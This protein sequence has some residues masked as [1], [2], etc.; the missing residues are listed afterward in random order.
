MPPEQYS[1]PV[2]VRYGETDQ[3]GVAHHAVYLTWFEEARTAFLAAKGCSYAELERQGWALPVRK[4][5]LRYRLP[6]RYEEELEV[7]VQVESS[8]SASI[9]F[10][11]RIS[12]GDGANGPPTLLASGSTELACVRRRGEEL[13][14]CAFPDELRQFLDAQSEGPRV[15]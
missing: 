3:M 14:P 1:H 2:R 9:T 15:D 10:A 7:L 5:D 6:A 11:Y 8:R 12:R 13:R 4:V